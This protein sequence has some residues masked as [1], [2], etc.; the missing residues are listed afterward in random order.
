MWQ[1]LTVF[2]QVQ[3]LYSLPCSQ[4]IATKAAKLLEE[5]V[6]IG[7]TRQPWTGGAE[8]LSWQRLAVGF[9]LLLGR[10]ADNYH[11]ERDAFLKQLKESHRVSDEDGKGQEAPAHSPESRKMGQQSKRPRLGTLLCLVNCLSC[12]FCLNPDSL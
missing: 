11:L 5:E 4:Q 9:V 2:S 1:S 10:M 12:C 3:V 6:Q 8:T 7:L